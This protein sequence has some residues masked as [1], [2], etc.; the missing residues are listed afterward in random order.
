M[1][2]LFKLQN[3][4]DWKTLLLTNGGLML[5]NK[6]YSTPDEFVEK[7]HEKGL[8]K[9]RME[10]AV[11]DITKIAY[12][13]KKPTSTT[14]TYLKKDKE[15]KLMLEFSS[16]AEQEEFVTTVAKSRNMTASTTQ[17]NVL[18]A[19]GPSLLAL[20]L[21]ALFTF[22]VHEDAKII[23]M[24]GEVNTSGRRSLYKKLFAWLGETLGTQGTL[25]AGA[26]AGL[27]CAYF[28][29]K[30]LKSKPVEVIYS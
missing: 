25:I 23:E 2:Q 17:V 11:S 10:L 21:T 12:P 20:G 5:V 13:E 15:S 19:I 18:K 16:Q 1:D 26:A 7:F 4:K 6:S 14:I 29:Y 3:E 30:N 27:L 9:Q 8:L 22:I 28:I 24:G